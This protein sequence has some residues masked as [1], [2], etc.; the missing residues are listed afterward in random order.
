MKKYLKET[1][2]CLLQFFMFYIFPLFAGPTDAMGMVLLILLAS[3]LLS[4]ILGVISNNKIKY[5]YPLFIALIFIP[6][7]WIYYNISALIH[8]IWY[9]IIS[10][11]GLFIGTIINKLNIKKLFKRN[12]FISI[13]II[14]IFISLLSIIP[15]RINYKDKTINNIEISSKDIMDKINNYFSNNN[16]TNSNM[17]YWT[18]DENKN[19]VIVGMIDISQ[20]KQN[21]FINNVFSNS[22]YI[23]YIKENKLI[24]FRESF[25]IFDGK[26]IEI[27]QDYIKVEVLKSSKSFQQNDQVIVKNNSTN[28]SYIIGNNIRITFN[29]MVETSNPPQ[30]SANKIEIINNN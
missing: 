25:D 12:Y 24:E 16:V 18:I 19:I 21:E 22:D 8:S 14:L 23:K 4:I 11:L 10:S 6:T 15:F 28:N 7:I 1:I 26:I 27:T 29:S 9:L 5:C 3:F 30:I 17:S 13:L 2:I 20:E